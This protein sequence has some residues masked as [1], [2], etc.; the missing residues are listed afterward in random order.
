[1]SRCRHLISPT[2]L[3]FTLLLAA[4]AGLAGVPQASAADFSVTSPGASYTINTAP[5][6]PTLTLVRGETYTFAVS[7]SSSHPFQI[8]GPPPTAFDRNNVSTGT[9]TFQV[10]TNAVNYSYRCSIHLF[11]GTIVTIPP[12]VV[13]IVNFDV[14]TNLVLTSTGT[15]NWMVHPEFSTNLNVSN[16][17]PLTIQSNRFANGTNETFCGTPPGTNVF[18]RIKAQRIPQ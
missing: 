13:R 8:V 7:T 16:W 9:I 1:M 14:G 15:N 10:P 3:A 2:C 4:L 17:S 11:T 18:I 6:N 12:P 5:S